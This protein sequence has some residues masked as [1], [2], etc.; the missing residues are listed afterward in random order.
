MNG[1]TNAMARASAIGMAATAVTKH[2][3]ETTSSPAR[4]SVSHAA[5]IPAA[6]A[7][8]MASATGSISAPCTTNRAVTIWPTGIVAAASFEDTSSSGASAQKASI[9]A[10]PGR[11]RSGAGM[12][13]GVALPGRRVKPRR[14]WTGAVGCDGRG[15]LRSQDGAVERRGGGGTGR[16][17][18]KTRRER[19]GSGCT[20][21]QDPWCEGC[22]GPRARYGKITA[23]R[24]WLEHG[25][26]GGESSFDRA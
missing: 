6:E 5:R 15:L 13:A 14:R 16:L 3:V 1:S 21:R 12:A 8:P 20:A 17:G 4:S 11:M 7:R 23:R 9:S 24:G 10:M 25:V 26:T 19:P 18:G 22:G 2:Q